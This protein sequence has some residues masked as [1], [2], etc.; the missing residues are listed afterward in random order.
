[1]DDL[2][3]V[4]SLTTDIPHVSWKP[5]LNTNGEVRVYNVLGKTNP[6]NA[7]WACPTNAAHQFFKVKM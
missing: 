6:V 1:D 5:N 2:R 7:V 3:A 4:F